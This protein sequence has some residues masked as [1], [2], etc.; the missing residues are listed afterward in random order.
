MGL[1]A[2]G[3]PNKIGANY[4][5]VLGRRVELH[6]ELA[7]L[8]PRS[9]Q[10]KKKLLADL[11]ISAAGASEKRNLPA[12]SVLGGSYTF[13]SGLTLTAEWHHDGEGLSG[14]ENRKVYDQIAVDS[15][16]AREALTL[17]DPGGFPAITQLVAASGMLGGV[18]QNKD[19]LFLMTGLLW[20]HEKFSMQLVALRQLQDGST[21]LIPS[22]NAQLHRNWQVY[23][24]PSFFMGKRESEYGSMITKMV[25]T[26]GL[27]YNL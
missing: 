25:L 1:V 26:M 13:R 21:A 17:G 24:R 22:F 14:S 15:A 20:G 27:R 18:R 7:L 3:S 6:G 19:T 11:S 12:Q 16:L 4:S 2:S 10:A 5:Y 23:L 9:P 8:F